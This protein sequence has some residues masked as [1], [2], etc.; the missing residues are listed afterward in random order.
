MWI[1][2]MSP[3]FRC[4]EQLG[5]RDPNREARRLSPRRFGR[6]RLE[7]DPVRLQGEVVL[8]EDGTPF[9]LSYRVECDDA[10]L[11]GRAKVQVKR[12]GVWDEL[13]VKRNT[14]LKAG[15]VH[16]PARPPP[17]RRRRR[18]PGPLN[19]CDRFCSSGGY[20]AGFAENLRFSATC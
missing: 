2:D 12:S 20:V 18:R 11:T 17:P 10:G 4:Y 15:A 16:R 3:S 1:V 14:L 6:D 9:A 5:H 7:W 13:T 19:R 8:V